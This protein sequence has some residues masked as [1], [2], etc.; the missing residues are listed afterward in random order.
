MLGR[1]GF[2]SAWNQWAALLTVGA[3]C[4]QFQRRKQNPRVAA[5][6]VR[7]VPALERVR[8]SRAIGEHQEELQWDNRNFSYNLHNVL[9][10]YDVP[11]HPGV[12]LYYREMGYMK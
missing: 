7:D 5:G 4:K 8:D 10:A 6:S 9:K 12:A 2:D 1:S 3:A 11:L